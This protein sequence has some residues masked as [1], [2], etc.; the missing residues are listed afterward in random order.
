M[1]RFIF[2]WVLALP[3]AG[4]AQPVPFT[5]DSIPVI[6]GKVVFS[7]DF[8]VDLS[9][10]ELRKRAYD[11]LNNTMDPYA[12]AFQADNED[13]TVCKITDYVPASGNFLQS[14]GMYMTYRLQLSY[15]DGICQLLI[16]DI[17]FMEKQYFEAQEQSARKLLR[18]PVHT[19]EEIMIDKSFSLLMIK[20]VSEKITEGSL[21]RING[22]ISGLHTAFTKP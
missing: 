3:I 22:I 17:S 19:A 7:A 18:L 10:K 16:R 11:Y 2:F 20:D 9:K 15:A 5:A 8:A 6:G 13:Q 21:K 12:G 14:F 1:K 4:L